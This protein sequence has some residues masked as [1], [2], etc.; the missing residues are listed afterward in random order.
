M[1]RLLLSVVIPSH[2]Q[3]ESLK[4]TLSSLEH[5]TIQNEQFEV[6]LVDDG[7]IDNTR[8]FGGRFNSTYSLR[9][10]FQENSGAAAARNRGAEEAKSELILFLDADMICDSELLSSHLRAH[11]NTSRVIVE[12]SRKPWHTAASPKYYRVID[13]DTNFLPNMHRGKNFGDM[14]SCNLSLRNCLFQEVGGFDTGLSRWEDVDFAFRAV[15]LGAQLKFVPEAVAYHNHP[16]PFT[17]YC[18]KQLRTHQVA[19]EL[20]HKHPGILDQIDYLS[21]R[22]KI[23]WSKDQFKLIIRKLIRQFLA[24]AP[25]LKSMEFSVF[26]LEKYFPADYLLKRLYTWIIASYQVIGLRLKDKTI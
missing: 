7:S 24:W 26:I 6:I 9:Y 15:Q 8:E 10:F 19:I 14:L 23:D 5:Q 4:E 17:E 22:V 3:G 11:R 20:A 25:I 21:D 2:N 1:E 13:V 16:M 12:G 18:Q